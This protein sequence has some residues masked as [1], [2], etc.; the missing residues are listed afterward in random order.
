MLPPPISQLL[1]SLTMPFGRFVAE[2]D[3]IMQTLV[4]TGLNASVW[5]ELPARKFFASLSEKNGGL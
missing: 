2:V 5:D 3:R 1:R 4:P